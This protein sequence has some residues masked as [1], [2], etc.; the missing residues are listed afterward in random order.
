MN[1][2]GRGRAVAYEMEGD[3]V[4]TSS[5]IVAGSSSYSWLIGVT[6]L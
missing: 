4:P 6:E 2:Y 5:L 3:V 1:D